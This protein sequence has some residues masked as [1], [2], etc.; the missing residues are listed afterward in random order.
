MKM[1]PLLPQGISVQEICAPLIEDSVFLQTI[2][3]DRA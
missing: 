1:V 2:E 3:R